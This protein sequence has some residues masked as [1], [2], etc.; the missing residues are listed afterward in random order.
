MVEQRLKNLE[1]KLRKSY[2]NDEAIFKIFKEQT[3]KIME[4]VES[5]KSEK[6]ALSVKRRKEI[7]TLEQNILLE[8]DN[9]L[10]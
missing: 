9:I 1:E 7:K 4:T 5:Q 10:Y 3:Q 6:E 2:Q 8:V